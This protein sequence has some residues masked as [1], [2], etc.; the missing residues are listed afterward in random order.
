MLNQGHSSQKATG[1]PDPTLRKL[2]FGIGSNLDTRHAYL[3]SPFLGYVGSS[4][5]VYCLLAR[6]MT[7]VLS[8]VR[9][10]HR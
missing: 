3:A 9:L 5:Y 7:A 6:F 10:L 4:G 2:V 8:H 1:A